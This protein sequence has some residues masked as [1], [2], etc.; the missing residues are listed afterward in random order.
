MRI[1]FINVIDETTGEGSHTVHNIINVIDERTGKESLT[2]HNMI[3]R[4][5]GKGKSYS[6]EYH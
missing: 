6:S 5:Y 3:R 2:F 4:N 1:Y